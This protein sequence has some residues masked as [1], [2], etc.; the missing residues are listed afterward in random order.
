MI[1]L[2]ALLMALLLGLA[3]CQ[4]TMGSPESTSQVV[5]EKTSDASI[6]GTITYRERVA[7][8]P[9]ATVASGAAGRFAGRRSLPP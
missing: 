7:L 6:S 4:G 5:S 2:F 9:D 3:S 8:A 1:S